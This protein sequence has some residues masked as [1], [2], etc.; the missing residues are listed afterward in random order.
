MSRNA[1]GLSKVM[2]RR[3]KVTF[4]QPAVSDLEALRDYYDEEGTSQAGIRLVQEIVERIER[5]GN[6]PLMGR[7]VPEFGVEH[8]R[9]IIHPPF[10]IVYRYDKTKVRVVR[11]WR[12]ER[13]L[14]LP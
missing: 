3:A 4:A 11:I 10:R 7:V 5:L 6:H 1:W 9:E 8:L 2:A 13:L 14:K 12:S